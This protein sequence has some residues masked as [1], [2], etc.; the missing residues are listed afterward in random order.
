MLC[1]R[2]AEPYIPLPDLRAELGLDE[3]WSGGGMKLY[4]AVG[5]DD[6][7]HTG[8][9]GR[10]VIFEFLPMDDRIRTLV[11]SHADSTVMQHAA[12][13]HGMRTLKQ[14]GLIKAL[15]GVTTIEEVVRVTQNG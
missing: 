2:C 1:K 5:C 13:E 10:T 11:L 15:E 8:Y 14:D 9:Q 4:K 6:C 3:L 7:A 12:V